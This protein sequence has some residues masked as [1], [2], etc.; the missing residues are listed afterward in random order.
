MRDSKWV[1]FHVTNQFPM[2][3]VWGRIPR[4]HLKSDRESAMT[5][6]VLAVDIE[7]RRTSHGGILTWS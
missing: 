3:T 6:A 5:K 7:L 2:F 1:P 4:L